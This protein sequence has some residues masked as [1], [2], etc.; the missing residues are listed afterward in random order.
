MRRG[1]WKLGIYVHK[2]TYVLKPV[3][4]QVIDCLQ[5]GGET[6]LDAVYSSKQNRNPPGASI[7][8]RVDR[9]QN[10]FIVV[11]VTKKSKPEEIENDE[12]GSCYFT[13]G[14]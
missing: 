10:I 1:D 2:I 5:W 8:A 4:S 3:F 14:G 12:C 13:L 11:S 9:Q 7:L 6:V